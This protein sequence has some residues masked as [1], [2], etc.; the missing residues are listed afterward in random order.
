MSSNILITGAAGYIGG[1]LVADF[2]ARNSPLIKKDQIHAAVRS[3]EQAEALSKLGI[4]VLQLDLTNEDAVVESVLRHNIS[5]VVHTASSLDVSLALPLVTALGRQ[6]EVSGA[7]TFFIHTSGL[8][9]FYERTGWPSGR[10]SD[11]GPVFETERQFADSYPLRKTDVTVIEHAKEKGVTSFIVVPSTVYGKGSGAWNQ[12]SVVLP[13]Y[14]QGCISNKSVY[15]FPQNMTVSGVHISDMTALYTTII[16]K[17]IQKE[18][19][20]SGTEGYY[21]ALAHDISWWELLD[22]LAKALHAR[23]LVT[24]S[25]TQVWPSDEAAAEALGIPVQYVQILWNSGDNLTTKNTYKLGWKP[26]WNKERFLQHLDDEIEAVQELGMAKSS[27]IASLFQSA[28]GP[29]AS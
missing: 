6:R 9:A 26:Q 24:E 19:P 7:D 3:D 10:M 1:S 5:I 28:K 23:G 4:H 16:E 15:K 14:V 13:I 21:F 20:P 25:K 8:S 29:N 12:L 27:L 11:A 2:L 22:H 17:V 18:T